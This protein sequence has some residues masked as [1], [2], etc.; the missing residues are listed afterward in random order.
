MLEYDHEKPQKWE[1]REKKAIQAVTKRSRPRLLR[2]PGQRDQVKGDSAT[3]SATAVTRRRATEGDDRSCQSCQW[4]SFILNTWSLQSSSA[5]RD[6]GAEGPRGRGDGEILR[7][8]PVTA[9]YITPL[10]VRLG[11]MWPWMTVTWW[12]RWFQL[13]YGRSTKNP[14]E[15]SEN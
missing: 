3:Q 14:P 5:G 12:M 13:L 1:Q 9:Q 10:T 11:G 4:T 7:L 15:E 8:L 2:A 6:P